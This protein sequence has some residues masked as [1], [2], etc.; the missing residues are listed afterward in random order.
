MNLDRELVMAA[1]S[2]WCSATNTMVLLLGLLGLTVLDITAILGTS[3]TDL[4]IDTSLFGYKFDLNLK[5]IFE[6]RVVE[7]L[8]K[9]NQRPSKRDAHKLHNNFFNYNTLITHF[10]GSEEG[11]RGLLILLV[12]QVHLLC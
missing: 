12:K 6:E 5:T 2:F 10:T 4:P 8:M 9:G 1:F 11:T 7:A 3:P